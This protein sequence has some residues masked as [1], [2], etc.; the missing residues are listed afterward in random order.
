[1]S[2]KYVEDFMFIYNQNSCHDMH[3]TFDNAG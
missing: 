3:V 2:V 1:M